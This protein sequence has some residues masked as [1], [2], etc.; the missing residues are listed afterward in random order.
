MAAAAV[1]KAALRSVQAHGRGAFTAVK[2]A[3]VSTGHPASLR[4]HALSSLLA[5]VLLATAVI[6][7]PIPRP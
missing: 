2:G 4:F 5:R 3:L 7:S 1:A 6:R